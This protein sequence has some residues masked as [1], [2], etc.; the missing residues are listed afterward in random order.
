MPVS[1]LEIEKRQVTVIRKV[2]VLR[3]TFEPLEVC[4]VVLK[5]VR[6]TEVVRLGL[7]EKA[8][9]VSNVKMLIDETTNEFL[10]CEVEIFFEDES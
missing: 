4:D 6:S 1:K 3:T 5:H 8:Q 10:G 7:S 2:P 9:P